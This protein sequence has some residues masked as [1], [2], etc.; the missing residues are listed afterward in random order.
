MKFL[1]CVA[2]GSFPSY[3]LEINTMK[4]LQELYKKYNE[5]L[6]VD[7][8]TNEIMVYNDYIE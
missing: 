6:I 2:D 8:E 1:V 4:E 3:E 7:F 5:Q